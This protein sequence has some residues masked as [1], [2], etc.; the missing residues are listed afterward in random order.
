MK[1]SRV[2]L[3][4]GVAA[5]SFSLALGPVAAVGTND[6]PP[7]V[8]QPASKPEPKAKQAKPAKKTKKEKRTDQQFLDGYR[9]GF[10]LIQAEKYEEAITAFRALKQDDH[11]DVANYI[12]YASRKLGRYGDA[13]AWYERALAADPK[14]A[15]TWQ[16][17]GMWHVEQGNMLKAKDHLAHIRSICGETCKEFTDLKGAMEGTVVY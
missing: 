6:P 1:M 8:Q 14:H 16:Y 2:A 10:N 17:Y 7:P 5:V 12:G 11:P 15:R 4:A 3:M 9:V 13:Q